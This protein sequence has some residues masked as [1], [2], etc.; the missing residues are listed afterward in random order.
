MTKQPVLKSLALQSRVPKSSNLNLPVNLHVLKS[1]V[2]ISHLIMALGLGAMSAQAQ[3]KIAPS[4]WVEDTPTPASSPRAVPSSSGRVPLQGGVQHSDELRP[5]P[6]NLQ[7]GAIY[8]EKSIPKTADDQGWYQIPDWLA[9]KWLREEETILS[10]YFF[11]SKVQQ[12][13]PRTIAERELAD[14][15]FQRDKNGKVWHTELLQREF[16]TAVVIL[17]LHLCNHKN[18]CM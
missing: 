18:R 14:F 8:D 6:Q 17:L 1:L 13:E 7:T 10:T 2:R 4:G 3:Q 11:D 15:G 16:Q 9:G 5:L 12:N